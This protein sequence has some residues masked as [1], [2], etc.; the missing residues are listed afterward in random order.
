MALNGERTLAELT[1]QF[2]VHP[3]QIGNWKFRLLEGTAGSFPSAG[4]VIRCV[5]ARCAQEIVVRG[6]GNTQDRTCRRA[7]TIGRATPCLE[8][9]DGGDRGEL[10]CAAVRGNRQLE[11]RD[12][13]L[14]RPCRAGGDPTD[15]RATVRPLTGRPSIVPADGLAIVK[16]AKIWVG[17]L[18]RGKVGDPIGGPAK[19]SVRLSIMRDGG[20]L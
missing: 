2:D 12:V 13:A 9:Q 7:G 4:F 5:L 8:P 15:H 11:Q 17:T 19:T 20:A 1:Q 10:T 18:A 14:C 6:I 3:N 16:G